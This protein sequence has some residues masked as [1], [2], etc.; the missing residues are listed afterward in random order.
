[1]VI[2]R[3]SGDVHYLLL[4]EYNKISD[5]DNKWLTAELFSENQEGVYDNTSICNKVIFLKLCIPNTTLKNI[6]LSKYYLYDQ[7]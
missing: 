3:Y 2:Y 4:F 7:Q 6:W 5:D 1:M